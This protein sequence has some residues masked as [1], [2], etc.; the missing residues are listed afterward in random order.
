MDK[1]PPARELQA[2]QRE[3]EREERRRAAGTED[4]EEVAQHERRAEK[5]AYLVRK[6]KE[7]AESEEKPQSS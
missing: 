2:S 7:R 3:R 5:A 6:L 4:E 1:D